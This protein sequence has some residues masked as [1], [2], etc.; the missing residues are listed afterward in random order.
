M[1]TIP[2][3]GSS[4]ARPV[5]HVFLSVLIA[6]FTLTNAI[7]SRA[8]NA[9][10]GGTVTTEDGVQLVH[11]PAT[12][13]QAAVTVPMQEQWRRGADESEEVIFGLLD[14]L[15][16]AKDG[17][18]YVLD[19]QLCVVQVFS[20]RGE[21]IRT[22]GRRGEGPGEFN[23]PRSV[24]VTPDGLVAVVQSMP[25][26]IVLLTPEGD[27]A[28][29]YPLPESDGFIVVQSAREAGGH[30][31]L[32]MRT[33]KR[34][35]NQFITDVE[36]IVGI[37]ADGAIAATFA[38]AERVTDMSKLEFNEK[39]MMPFSAWAGGA[40]GTVYVCDRFDDYRIGVWSPEGKE[41]RVIEREFEPR[42]RS[43]A[44][45]ERRG[46]MVRVSNGDG[47]LKSTVT[48]SPTDRTVMNIIP[49]ENGVVWVLTSRGSFDTARGELCTLD[50]FDADGRF[51]RQIH[52]MGE[53]N[54][55]KDAIVI[56]GNRL[57]VLTDRQ[58]ARAAVMG[59]ETKEDEN[60]EP[61]PMTLIC[62]QLDR[63]LTMKD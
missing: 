38:R 1:S 61:E 26:K 18:V 59:A 40:D 42:V 3:S 46:P 58:S 9:K 21:Y 55:D 27:A 20:P 22:I 5:S 33:T 16:V 4:R 11:N 62:Y 12:P 37:G 15:A 39:K 45:R 23:M 19:S 53:G 25:G 30:V 6:V 35:E 17:T 8:A 29:N 24:F 36:E 50:E 48:K 10:W 60:A 34:G 7:A 56:A 41:V 51:V 52:L 2:C 47:T 31:L 13:M 54:L 44:E 57:F 28:D 14:D 49:R 43:D 32:D 63:S